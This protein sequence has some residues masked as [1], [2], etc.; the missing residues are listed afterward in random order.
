LTLVFLTAETS[1]TIDLAT[2]TVALSQCIE[3]RIA[4]VRTQATFT[5]LVPDRLFDL[6]DLR[7]HVYYYILS[8]ANFALI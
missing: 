3:H 5:L 6:D 1:V 8:R 7:F 4:R 2:R